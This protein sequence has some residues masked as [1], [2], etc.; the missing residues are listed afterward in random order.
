MTNKNECIEAVNEYFRPM[1]ERRAQLDEASVLEILQQGAAKATEV[2]AATMV[3][4]RAA[5]GLLA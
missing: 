3:E 4:V 5:M 2:A 1:R